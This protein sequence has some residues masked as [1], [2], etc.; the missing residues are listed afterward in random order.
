MDALEDALI[1]RGAESDTTAAIFMLKS[2]RRD[3]YGDKQ[4]VTQRGTINH[5]HT[6]DLSR[7]TDD[8]LEQLR[9]LSEKIER[10]EVSG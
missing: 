10:G 8:E 9:T 6:H 2:W 4:E 1:D 3:R 7:L 5:A